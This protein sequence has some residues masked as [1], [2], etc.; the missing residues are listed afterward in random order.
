MAAVYGEFRFIYKQYID[1]NCGN[2]DKIMTSSLQNPV[3]FLL[4]P[5]PEFT[6]LPFA[7]FLDKLRFSADDADHSQQRYC[8]WQ[9]TCL[10]PLSDGIQ[11]EKHTLVH[12]SCGVQVAVNHTINSVSFEGVDYLVLFG[13]RSPRK[14]NQHA[15]QLKG[16]LRQA[17]VQ[18]VTLVAV[19]NA[20]FILAACG[21]LDHKSVAIHWR[22]QQEFSASF[23]KVKLLEE[24]LFCLDGNPMTSVGGTAAIDLA[25][26]LLARKTGRERALKG[27]ADMIVDE[28]RS[29]HHKLK[30]IPDTAPPNRHL[31]R[32]ISL[33]RNYLSE[34]ISIEQ[35][36]QQIGLSRRQLDRQFKQAFDHSAHA[37]W[38][39]M[40]LQH[41]HW[42]L[43]NSHH[44]LSILSEEVG[45]KDTR[46]LS[47]LIRK[48]FGQTPAEIRRA[49]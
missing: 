37:Y 34:D 2:L 36:A 20:S 13:S 16:T 30:S 23:P 15:K 31:H 25:V 19:D 42:R 48:R 46:Y 5:L 41:V 14:A 32:A 1:I 4:L 17:M 8:R 6:L 33:M 49:S 26:E 28:P 40:R 11:K 35:I 29:N 3:S 10:D 43:I 38:T 27:L 9:L 21:L 22:H 12:S 39:E 7:G 45:I 24:D 44:N 18:G 47:K